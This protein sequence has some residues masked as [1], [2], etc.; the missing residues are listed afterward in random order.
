RATQ[1]RARE[2]RTNGPPELDLGRW[3]AVPEEGAQHALVEREQLD[4]GGAR[5]AAVHRTRAVTDQ[6]EAHALGVESRDQST[7][8]HERV[9]SV[10]VYE[11]FRGL[12]TRSERRLPAR[13]PR[14]HADLGVRE[15]LVR[16]GPLL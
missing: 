4:V 12:A 14:L 7:V 9:S 6:A 11:L 1:R 16:I 10:R 8:D 2:L 5:H 15:H 13:R 3:R